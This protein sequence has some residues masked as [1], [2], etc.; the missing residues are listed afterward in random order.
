[1][2]VDEIGS[3]GCP[4]IV[5]NV[6]QAMSYGLRP[7]TVQL[8]AT[9]VQWMAVLQRYSLSSV[10]LA[11]GCRTRASRVTELRPNGKIW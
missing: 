8:Q 9:S 7:Y 5:V 10:A 2:R 11:V 1:M 4:E 6:S 3:G